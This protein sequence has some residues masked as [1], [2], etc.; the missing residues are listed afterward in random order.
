MAEEVLDIAGIEPDPVALEHFH[1]DDGLDFHGESTH[2]LTLPSEVGLFRGLT[3]V[4]GT[5][6]FV[7]ALKAE[8]VKVVPVTKSGV[9]W[10]KHARPA[11]L[12]AW[13]AK[14]ILNH[15]TGP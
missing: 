9:A 4:I 8:G 12:G 5:T 6:K 13:D 2:S 11:S 15:H 1:A 10:Y 14:G 7:N 3:S